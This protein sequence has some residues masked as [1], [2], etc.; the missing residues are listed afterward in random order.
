VVGHALEAQAA[1]L[2]VRVREH[3]AV[4]RQHRAALREAAAALAEV[5]RQCKA[6]GIGFY[7]TG[8]E[9]T[10]GRRPQDRDP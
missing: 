4:I 5:E 2:R 6:L 7:L 9:V 3:K 8:G 1:R 10:H